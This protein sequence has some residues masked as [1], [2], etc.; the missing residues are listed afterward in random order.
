[1]YIASHDFHSQAMTVL[2]VL[3]Q[4]VGKRQP[5]LFLSFRSSVKI[6]TGYLPWF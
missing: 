1:M 3:K 6:L 2:D 4:E 5:L